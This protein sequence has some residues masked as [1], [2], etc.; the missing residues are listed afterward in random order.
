[1][2]WFWGSWKSLDIVVLVISSEYLTNSRCH[3]YWKDR[4]NI[5]YDTQKYIVFIEFLLEYV[6]QSYATHL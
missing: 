2:A 3:I 4:F 5:M 6:F 1:M